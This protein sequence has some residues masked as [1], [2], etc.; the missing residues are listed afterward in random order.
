MKIYSKKNKKQ[1]NGRGLFGIVY[2]IID[3][4]TGKLKVGR[5]ETPLG[6]RKSRYL[7][8]AINQLDLKD[9]ITVRIRELVARGGKDL[10]KNTFQWIP[11]EIVLR[12]GSTDEHIAHD[13]KLIENLEQLWQ[14]KLGSSDPRYGYDRTS[15]APGKHA[16]S[17]PPTSI[18]IKLP[19]VFIN[20]HELQGLLEKGCDYN[21]MLNIL[22]RNYLGITKKDI[23]DNIKY[24]WP[25]LTRGL[26]SL[27]PQNQPLSLLKKAKF[28]FIAQIVKTYVENGYNIQ[29]EIASM[30]QSQENPRGISKDTILRVVKQEY[31]VNSW[32]GFLSLHGAELSPYSLMHLDIREFMNVGGKSL[33]DYIKF[34]LSTYIVKGLSER[35]ILEELRAD[36]TIHLNSLQSLQRY[37]YKFWG[38]LANARRVLVAPI[39]SLCFKRG[40]TSAQIRERVPF[41]QKW[42]S[43]LKAGDAVRLFCKQWF[44]INPTQARNILR[45]RS[46]NEFLNQYLYNQ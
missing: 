3:W 5:T 15:G 28:Y 7:Y 17:Y 2:L 26:N 8:N 4:E 21:Q 29:S 32:A 24:H 45:H 42:G 27:T 46:L 12:S 36:Q 18:E 30:F 40:Y 10:A 16:E 25:F 11:I 14:N 22:S 39:L 41:F 20:P 37:I 35:E 9:P 31:G 44:T 6:T 43:R 23:Y 33:E 38:S 34:T 19:R 13:R 1:Y